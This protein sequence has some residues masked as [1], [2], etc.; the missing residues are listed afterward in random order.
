[1]KVVLLRHGKPRLPDSKRMTGVAF[2]N[3]INS[4]DGA[5]LDTRVPPPKQ[6]ILA[7][8]GCSVAV[9]STLARSI[10]SSE[11][12]GISKEMEISD[13]FVEASLPNYNVLN[14]KFPEQFWLVFF[15]ISWFLGYSPN[16]ESYSQVKVR[17]KICSERLAALAKENGSVIFVGHGILNR[18]ISRELRNLGWCGSAKTKSNYWQFSVYENET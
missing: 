14:L 7:A 18:L 3:W 1:M 15:R 6:S 5:P 2:G 4:Y 16:S 12:L 13:T 11:M 10:E 9:C 17:A 8:R